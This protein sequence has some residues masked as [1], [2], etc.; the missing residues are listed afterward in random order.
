MTKP[1]TTIS[2][3]KATLQDQLSQL[4]FEKCGDDLE[5]ANHALVSVYCPNIEIFWREFVVPLTNRIAP[6]GQGQEIRFR[7]GVDP[8]LQYIAAA[9]YS[10]FVNLALAHQSLKAWNTLAQDTVYGRLASACDVFEALIIKSY[11]LICECRNAAPRPVA[12]LTKD[13]FLKLA[14]EHYDKHYPT[15]KEFYLSVGKKPP[16]ILIP[17][18][19]S[20]IDEFFRVNSIKSRYRKAAND[21]RT[22]RNPILH[23]VRLGMLQDTR[24]GLLVPKPDVLHKYKKWH[25]VE[26]ASK[27]PSTIEKDFSD[28]RLL[29][30]KLAEA[31]MKSINEV[32]SVLLDLFRTEF[33]SGSSDKMRELMGLRFETTQIVTIT[34]AFS[35]SRANVSSSF[36]TTN[37][38]GVS[39]YYPFPL[40]DVPD[41]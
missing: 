31:L 28:A 7:E 33:N 15:L 24:G 30:V 29:C 12:D 40:R 39:G 13:E 20:I 17:S 2:V 10:L 5:R 6:D 16:Q 41:A 38:S 11:F 35:P 34:N 37:V 23:D 36:Q 26:C 19:E 4:S 8:F 32:Y 18:N 25:E 27:E 14:G 22:F 21:V 1:T 3:D 9:N